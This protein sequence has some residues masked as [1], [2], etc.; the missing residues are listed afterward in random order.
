MINLWIKLIHFYLIKAQ[1]LYSR[2]LLSQA[3][4][5]SCS[6]YIRK[7]QVLFQSD[8]LDNMSI[9]VLTH[10]HKSFVH[11]FGIG[12][13]SSYYLW[14]KLLLLDLKM[15]KKEKKERQTFRP[16]MGALFS[17]INT[18]IHSKWIFAPRARDLIVAL[19]APIFRDFA[20]GLVLF[21]YI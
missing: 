13:V 8:M 4:N 9:I 5:N 6:H 10:I 7:F 11:F 15:R 17:A 20:L 21:A 19:R 3:L 16:H 12:S 18:K 14:S 2:Y 1:K